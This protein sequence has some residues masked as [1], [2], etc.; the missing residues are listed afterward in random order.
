MNEIVCISGP[1]DSY[2]EAE[3]MWERHYGGED[4]PYWVQEVRPR[5]WYIVSDAEYEGETK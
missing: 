3:V 2:D 5:A 4:G 1:Y